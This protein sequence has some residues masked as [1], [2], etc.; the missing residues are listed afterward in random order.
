MGFYEDRVLPRA[1]DLMLGNKA[2]GKLR[3]RALAGLW[4][5]VVEIGF[6][7]G[8]NIGHYPAAVT[9]IVAVD[10]SGG[11]RRIAEK[12]I[13][14]STIPIEFIGLN[15]ESL[16]LEDDSVD[17]ALSTWTLCTIPNVEAALSEIRR[18]VRPGGGLWFIEHGI[19]P[20]AGV[21]RRQHR[22][23]P[24]QKRIAGGC[25]L[26]RQH[27]HLLADAGFKLE[28]ISQFDIAGPKIS[29]HMFS[30]IARV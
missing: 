29:S 27:E 23:E 21:S 8:T 22:F 28:L 3:D 24:L 6:G 30:G 20:N 2:M 17:N 13:A 26:T 4:G 11:G 16:P 15:G 5:E 7:S 18:V 9:K 10:P 12:R 25:H 14:A 19:S 1:I